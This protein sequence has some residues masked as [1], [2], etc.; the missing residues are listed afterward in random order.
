M[1]DC[2]DKV[3]DI[4]F[5]ELKIMLKYYQVFRNKEEEVRLSSEGFDIRMLLL[6]STGRIFRK[7]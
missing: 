6:N 2:A 3:T 1:E 7:E 4:Y 5:E